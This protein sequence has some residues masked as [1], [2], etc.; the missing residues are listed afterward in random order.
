MAILHETVYP[1]IKSVFRVDN[2]DIRVLNVLSAKINHMALLE[3]AFLA[4][5]SDIEL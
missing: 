3:N 5:I 2:L 4:E 1:K